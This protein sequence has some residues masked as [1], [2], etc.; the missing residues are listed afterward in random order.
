MHYAALLIGSDVENKLAPFHE[1]ECT[2]WEN[3][4]IEEIDITNEARKEYT[5]HTKTFHVSPTGE[6]ISAHDKQFY[7]DPTPEEKEKIGPIGGMGWGD[8]MHWDSRDWSDGLEYRTKVHFLPE[9]WTKIEVPDTEYRSFVKFVESYHG[10]ETVPFGQTPDKAGV[11][12]YGYALLDENGEV[13]QIVKRT[14]PNAHWDWYQIGGRWSGFFKLK[15]EAVGN[16]GLGEPSLIDVRT[17]GYKPPAR[18][19][20]D[21]ARKCDIDIAGMRQE[22]AD[23]TAKT[24]DLVHSILASIPEKFEPFEVVLKRHCPDMQDI[25]DYPEGESEEAAEARAKA[26]KAAREEYRNQPGVQAIRQNPETTGIWDLDDWATA[27]REDFIE[28]ARNGALTLYAVIMNGQWYERGKSEYREKKVWFGNG[29][30]GEDDTA[31]WGAEFNKLID[32]LPDDT[33]LTVVDC[34]I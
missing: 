32:S 30:C 3:E 20:V 23:R 1:F 11:H 17:P 29:H 12:K 24:Y 9:G 31:L 19:R 22:A 7:R 34:H 25:D 8:G 4:Y 13:T 10:Y 21:Q 26:V 5:K 27:N 18:D 33:L 14:N 16:G 28:N 6:R 2:G 15:P